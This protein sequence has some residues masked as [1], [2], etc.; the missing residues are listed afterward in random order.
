[1][2]VRKSKAAIIQSS[3]ISEFLLGKHVGSFPSKVGIHG[4]AAPP[5]EDPGSLWTH[6]QQAHL[7]LVQLTFENIFLC[8]HSAICCA[9][10][11][12]RLEH[13]Q[14]WCQSHLVSRQVKGR[15]GK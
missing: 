11:A 12:S 9:V 14:A 7:C 5:G 15:I 4:C 2:I 3:D 8:K 10:E 13:K 1:M 6:L